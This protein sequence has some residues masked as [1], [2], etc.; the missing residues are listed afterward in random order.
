MSG[1]TVFGLIVGVIIVAIV[2]LLIFYLKTSEKKPISNGSA[3][4]TM[5]GATGPV[6]HD[7]LTIIEGIGPKI[8][9]LLKEKGVT[10]YKALSKMEPAKIAAI[11]KQGGVNLADSSTWPEQAG[12]L[13]E[14]KMKELKAL[15]TNL[16]G[17]RRK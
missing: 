17:G 15:Q 6:R 10:T 1:N 9:G 5:V 13:A 3:K 2:L 16:K 4:K 8:S 7:D 11:L 14:G 12:L